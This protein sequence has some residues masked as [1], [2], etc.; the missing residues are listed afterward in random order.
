VQGRTQQQRESKNA[1]W[2]IMGKFGWDFVKT[3]EGFGIPR[4]DLC[5][6][7][8]SI[9]DLLMFEKQTPMHGLGLLSGPFSKR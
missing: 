3:D 4:T 8:G 2:V 5:P 7:V 9:S 1:L 6:S